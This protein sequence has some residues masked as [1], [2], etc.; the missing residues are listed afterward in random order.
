MEYMDEKGKIYEISYSQKLQREQNK[1]SRHKNVLLFCILIL[2]VG[3]GVGIAYL[4]LRLET[5]DF[6][7]KVMSVLNKS[8]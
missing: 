3:F 4:Y 6:L 5:I 8:I 7:T 2:L 1:L